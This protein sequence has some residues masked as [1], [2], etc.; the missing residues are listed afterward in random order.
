MGFFSGTILGVIKGDAR[1]LGCSSYGKV[2]F[3]SHSRSA[4]ARKKARSNYF[5]T[6]SFV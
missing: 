5:S 1:S 6:D 3:A 4:N 2:S